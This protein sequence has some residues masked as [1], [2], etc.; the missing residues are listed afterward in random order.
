M[1]LCSGRVWRASWTSADRQVTEPLPSGIVKTAV[2][3]VT[4]ATP[5]P[6]CPTGVVSVCNRRHSAELPTRANAALA[7]GPCPWRPGVGIWETCLPASPDLLPKLFGGD[8]TG[9]SGNSQGPVPQASRRVHLDVIM[10]SRAGLRYHP[11][12]LLIPPNCPAPVLRGP[13]GQL[14]PFTCLRSPR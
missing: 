5:P 1:N 12:L 11:H 14:L 4:I 6:P 2:D 13:K 10:L 7:P 3:G 9:V 8:G